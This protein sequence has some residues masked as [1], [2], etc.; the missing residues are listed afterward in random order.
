LLAAG[1][2]AGVGYAIG[3]ESPSQFSRDYR[4]LFGAPPGRDGAA[5][6]A[7]LT[8]EPTLP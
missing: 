4:R 1:D 7:R 2:V 3:Y 8:A 6:R 5:I